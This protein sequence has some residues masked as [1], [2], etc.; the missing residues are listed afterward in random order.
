LGTNVSWSFG[1][2][3][4]VGT[5]YQNAKLRKNIGLK[6]ISCPGLASEQFTSE[7]TLE[8]VTCVS[9]KQLRQSILC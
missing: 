1:T 4:T 2:G 9:V 7:L 8:L 3:P 6:L 5:Y